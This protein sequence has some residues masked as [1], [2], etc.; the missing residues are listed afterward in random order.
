MAENAYK[1]HNH[2]SSS[3]GHCG[4]LN[5][6]VHNFL[7]QVD[8]SIVT[9]IWLLDVLYLQSSSDCHNRSGGILLQS[10]GMLLQSGGMLLQSG[11]MLLHMCAGVY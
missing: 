6:F 8:P 2:L 9:F 4:V 7:F 10:G 11:G 3:H 5:S 1:K